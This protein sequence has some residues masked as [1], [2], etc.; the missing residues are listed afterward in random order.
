MTDAGAVMIVRHTPGVGA[1]LDIAT[2][3]HTPVLTLHTLAD[4]VVA[5]VQVGRAARALTALP[6]IIGV[7]LEPGETETGP[8]LAHSVGSTPLGAAEV[9]HQGLVSIAALKW[10]SLVSRLTATVESSGGVDTDRVPAAGT[11]SAALVDVVTPDEGVAI[12]ALLTLAH[13]AS[14]A[15]GGAL[16][17]GPAL[18]GHC[19]THIS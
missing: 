1:A 15:I 4:L 5:A 16:S 12:I 19:H 18:T 17:I 2:G 9:R 11:S 6:H 8:V 10:V 14:V 3:V 7:T 13:L